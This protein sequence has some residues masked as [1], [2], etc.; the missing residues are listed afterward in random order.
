VYSEVYE[1]TF[2]VIKSDLEVTRTKLASLDEL[3]SNENYEK[4]LSHVRG[5]SHSYRWMQENRLFPVSVMAH[6]VYVT[7][8]SYVIGTIENEE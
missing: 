3:L 2:K 5:L 6:L 4:Y 1:K 7:F 8:I